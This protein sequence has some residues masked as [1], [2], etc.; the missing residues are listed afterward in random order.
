MVSA[1][2]MQPIEGMILLS[3][4]RQPVMLGDRVNKGG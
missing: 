2:A 1:T 4:F 3:F